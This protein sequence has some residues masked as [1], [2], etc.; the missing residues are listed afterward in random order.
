MTCDQGKEKES[1]S[2]WGERPEEGEEVVVSSPE[3]GSRWIS[4]SGWKIKEVS[5]GEKWG[6]GRSWDACQ[7]LCASFQ[8]SWA[9]SAGEQRGAAW[10]QG[11]WWGLCL[12]SF[13]QMSLSIYLFRMH[14][15]S[16]LTLCAPMDCNPPGSSI[17]GIFQARILSGLPFPSPAALPDPR[18]EP[19]SPAVPALAGRFFTTELLGKPILYLVLIKYKIDN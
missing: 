18:T 10:G 3:A 2:Y 4:Q 5:R 7:A 8:W 13:P 15:Q 11:A 6:A 1:Y 9:G 19:S 16:C 14:A 17:H 12:L